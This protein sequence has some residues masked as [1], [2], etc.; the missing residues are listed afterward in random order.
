MT[1]ASA[2]FA[3]P[4]TR[5]RGSFAMRGGW[6]VY[7]MH[8]IYYNNIVVY[9]VVGT[10]P[11]DFKHIRAETRL[12]VIGGVDEV[13]VGWWVWG[14]CVLLGLTVLRHGYESRAQ[15]YRTHWCNIR[16]AISISR[17]YM[18]LRPPQSKTT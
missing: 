12:I 17:V 18:V 5:S 13:V 4:N 16:F 14:G 6:V 1:L 7:A 8:I 9:Y 11:Y 3:L 15:R 2:Y 10:C